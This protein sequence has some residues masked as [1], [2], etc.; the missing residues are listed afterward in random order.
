MRGSL[1]CLQC[2][3]TARTGFGVHGVP[4]SPW[5]IVT[6]TSAAWLAMLGLTVAGLLSVLERQDRQLELLQQQRNA[7]SAE[8]QGR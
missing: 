5:R 8:R 7:V 3:S 4:A 2:F 6:W 1:R